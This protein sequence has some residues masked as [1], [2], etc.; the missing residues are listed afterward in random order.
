MHDQSSGRPPSWIRVSACALFVALA[1]GFSHAALAASPDAELQELRSMIEALQRKIDT[2]EQRHSGTAVAAAPPAEA[3]NLL[4][5][6]LKIYGSLDSGVERTTNVGASGKTLSR[7]PSTTGSGPSVIGLDFRRSV[8][9]AVTAIG[10]AEMGLFL[11]TGSSGQGGR[12]FGRQLYVGLE[13]PLGSLSFGRQYSMFFYSLHGADI[14]GPNIH[15]LA[16]IDAYVPNARADNAV[17]WRAKFGQLSLGAHYSFGRETVSGTV[18]AS[19]ACGGEDASDPSRC[20]SWSAMLRYDDPAFGLAAG[21]D[22]QRGGSGA[23]ASFFNGAAPIAMASA[24]STDRRMTVNGYVRF[25]ALKLGAGWLGRKVDADAEDVEQDVI[26]LAGEYALAPRW[27]LDGSLFHVDNDAGGRRAN[28][29]AL[30]GFYKFDEQLSTYL[31]VGYVDNSGNAAYG[32]SA[33]GGGAAPAAGRS[34][35]GTMAGVRYRF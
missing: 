19:G 10:K 24:S 15:G 2:L 16:S 14:L 34:Q 5:Q 7:V 20:R 27:T 4:P 23:Q 11:D 12:I 8:G 1:A 6:G 35:L 28:L 22:T 18:P 13:T 17:A 30:R 25:G 21:I 26:W 29:Y 9:D 3:G 31:S 32:V 33:G